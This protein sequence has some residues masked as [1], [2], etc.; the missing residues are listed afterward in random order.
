VKPPWLNM[1]GTAVKTDLL[2][3]SSRTAQEITTSETAA[4]S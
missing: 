3:A 2:G 4:W 1:G